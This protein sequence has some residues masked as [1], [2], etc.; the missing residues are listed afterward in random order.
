MAPAQ[1]PQ[2][3][4]LERLDAEREAVHAGI[5]QGDESLDFGRARVGLERDLDV[6]FD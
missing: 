6:R 4:I 3:A 1:C 2:C 5:T